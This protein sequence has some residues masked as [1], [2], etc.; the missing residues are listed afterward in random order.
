MQEKNPAADCP[1]N[2]IHRQPRL[3]PHFDK[4]SEKTIGKNI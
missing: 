2:V 1:V 3:Y 4:K